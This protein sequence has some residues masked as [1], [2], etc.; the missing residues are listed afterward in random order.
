MIVAD[1]NI[2]I[3]HLR[4][5]DARLGALA[6]RRQVAIHPYTIGELALGS[7]ADRRALFRELGRFPH[8]PAARHDEVLG[9]IEDEQL[10]GTGIGYVDTHLLA[11]A[12]LL[13]DGRLWTRDKRL[14]AVAAR[15]GLAYDP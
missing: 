8:A 7:F 5:A 14:H 9:L 1:A 2:W 15:L 13:S 3:D 11:S 6:F 12:R 4:A 10:F